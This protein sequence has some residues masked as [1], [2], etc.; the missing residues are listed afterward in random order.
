M[1]I[2][3]K[4][5][6]RQMV[7]VKKFNKSFKIISRLKL[8]GENFYQLNNFDYGF[9]RIFSEDELDLIKINK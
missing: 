7:L 4:F 2:K 5:K 1:G 6:E 3:F 8:N 9:G